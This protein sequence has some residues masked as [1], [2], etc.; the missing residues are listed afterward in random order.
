MEFRISRR[1]VVG[2]VAFTA[3]LLVL[4]ILQA[5]ISA[6]AGTALEVVRV[7]DRNT[8]PPGGAEA[9]EATCPRGMRL[10]GGGFGAFSSDASATMQVPIAMPFNTWRTW[11][12]VAVNPSEQDGIVIARGTCANVT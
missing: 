11:R 4:L 1:L 5:D 8:V 12:V 10:I 9:A 2:W 3:L 7:S 6:R